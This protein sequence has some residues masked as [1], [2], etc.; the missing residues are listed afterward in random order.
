MSLINLQNLNIN[1][2]KY[3]DLKNGADYNTFFN[4]IP[5]SQFK[6]QFEAIIQQ[7]SIADKMPA[8]SLSGG[9]DSYIVMN[10]FTKLQEDCSSF[11]LGFE[12][13]SFDESR[14]VK[15]IKKKL[16]KRIYYADKNKL[17]SSFLKI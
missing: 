5:E 4:K 8:L 11:T 15:K 9:I 3:W 10:Y 16:N 13:K 6:H 1:K 2:K 12:N 14:Y 7:H 17:I